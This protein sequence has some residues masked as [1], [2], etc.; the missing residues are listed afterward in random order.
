MGGDWSSDVGSSCLSF[1]KGL[2]GAGAQGANFIGM[3]FPGNFTLG[4][5]ANRNL[6][7]D[8]SDLKL[9]AAGQL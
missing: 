7:F 4:D 1:T 2:L 9:A 3:T 6:R 8:D 5:A